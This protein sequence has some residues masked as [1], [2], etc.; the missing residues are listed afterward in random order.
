MSEAVLGQ[1]NAKLEEAIEDLRV[2]YERKAKEE[3]AAARADAAAAAAAGGGAG[4]AAG[5]SAGGAKP[6]EAEADWALDDPDLEALRRSRMA[7]LR[8]TVDA[9]KA[10]RAAGGGELRTIVEDD[11]LKEVTSAKMVV[12]HFYHPEFETCKV[13]DKHLRLVAA[14]PTAVT[15]RFL[16]LDGAY[17]SVRSGRCGRW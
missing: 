2:K 6:A 13:M 4:G 14:K 17:A 15:T 11:F 12:V 8:S 1:A 3:A 16:R 10:A 9:R 7:A 5:A